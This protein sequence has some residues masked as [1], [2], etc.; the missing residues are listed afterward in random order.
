MTN[1]RVKD[2]SVV[3]CIESTTV[4]CL[5]VVVVVVVVD[6]VVVLKYN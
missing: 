2:D 1:K 5:V 6:F 4:H 3:T